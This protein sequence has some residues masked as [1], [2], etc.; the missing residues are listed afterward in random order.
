MEFLVSVL[1]LIVLAVL[2]LRYGH[3]SRDMMQSKEQQLACFGMQWPAYGG[4]P[5]PRPVKRLGQRRRVQRR[6][7]RGLLALAE[8]LS[9]GT[10]ASLAR[11]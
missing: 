9:P 5:V 1:V 7:A 11:G 10:P 2:A 4:V 6:V 3:D 8:W